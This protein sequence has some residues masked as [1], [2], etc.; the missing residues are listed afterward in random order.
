GGKCPRQTRGSSPSRV[1]CPSAH[2]SIAIRSEI[3][4]KLL[5]VPHGKLIGGRNDE[6]VLVVDRREALLSSAIVP[7]LRGTLRPLLA[8]AAGI[9]YVSQI[10]SPRVGAVVLQAVTVF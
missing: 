5:A 2:Q 8:L 3:C 4:C 1:E 6:V 7:V 10:L 9:P